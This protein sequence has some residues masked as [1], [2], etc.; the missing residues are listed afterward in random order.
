MLQFHTFN[1][2]T[3][4]NKVILTGN[5]YEPRPCIKREIEHMKKLGSMKTN[6]EVGLAGKRLIESRFNAWYRTLEYHNKQITPYSLEKEKRFVLITLTLPFKQMHDDYELKRRALKP[7]IKYLERNQGMLNWAWKA[8]AQKNGN[9]HFHIVT[10]LFIPKEVIDGQ[11]RHYMLALGYL[12][13]FWEKFPGK[14]PPMT[15]VTGQG[16]MKNPV[17]YLTKYF[18]KKENKRKID[19]A[20]W[21]M[22]RNLLHLENFNVEVLSSQI[23]KWLQSDMSNVRRVHDE[24]FYLVFIMKK[25]VRI[26][27]IMP[28][29]EWAEFKHWHQQLEILENRNPQRW[30]PVES[31]KALSKV[32]ADIING[33]RGFYPLIHQLLIPGFDAL[34]PARF[35][36]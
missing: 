19:G 34:D 20:I 30:E 13:K 1:L 23:D 22:S 16:E 11:W 4:N 25:P 12:Q 6:G 2:S 17:A 29:Y 5:N 9:I 14:N 24:D 15:N 18:E 26:S 10:D 21:R 35:R 32:P 27:D 31:A 8:E 7:F 28:E 33:E 3:R 36:Q